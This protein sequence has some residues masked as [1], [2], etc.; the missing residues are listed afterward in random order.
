MHTAFSTELNRMIGEMTA[1]TG[2]K[3]ENIYEV[4]YSGNTCM[5][6]L[7]CAIDPAGLGRYPYKPAI[8]G[9]CHLSAL[10]GGLSVA[11]HA[12]IYLPPIISGFVGADITSG[13]V[14][15][16]FHDRKETTLFIDIGT[17][18]KWSCATRGTCGRHRPRPDRP[19]K[20]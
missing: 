6:H 18:G 16:G 19:S 8:D 5:L 15:T 12:L 10:D 3:K 4:V 1:G 7:A 9:D 17:T 20:A 13:M 11:G 2:T 14:A